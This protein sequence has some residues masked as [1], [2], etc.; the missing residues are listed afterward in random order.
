M[1]QGRRKKG[2]MTLLFGQKNYLE[3]APDGL[4]LS[5]TAGKGTGLVCTCS[6][7]GGEEKV[8]PA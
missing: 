5:G 8:Y 1:V 2:L 7:G 4:S 6:S 3:T